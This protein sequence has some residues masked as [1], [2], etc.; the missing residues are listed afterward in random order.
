MPALRGV[1]AGPGTAVPDS[2]ATP[3]RGPSVLL[4]LPDVPFPLRRN[5]I[6]MRYA[7]IIE[8]LGR[9][10]RLHLMLIL[11]EALTDAD[12]ALI[13]PHVEQLSVHVR[14][15]R[16]W[17]LSQRVATRLRNLLPGARPLWSIAHDE[18][19]IRRFVAASTASARYDVA[20]VV[21]PRHVD[22]VRAEAPCER[23]V[24]DAIDSMTVLLERSR[25]TGFFDRLE[26]RRTRRWERSRAAHADFW[27]YVSAYDAA[28]V[29]GEHRDPTRIGVVPNGY[30]RDDHTVERVALPG[31]AIGFLG[32]M[33]YPPNIRAVQRLVPIFRAV[34]RRVPDAVLLIIGRTPAPE[35]TALGAEPGVIVTGTLESIWPHVNATSAFAFPME[36]GAG[37]QNKLLDAM[38]AGVPVVTTPV[39]NSG[40]GAVDG[41]S[42]LIREDDAAFVEVLTALLTDRAMRERIGRQGQAFC[43]ATFD[44]GATLAGIERHYLGMS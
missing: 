40:V 44:W 39:G 30:S 15:H 17:P 34:R 18:A 38:A 37:Q 20:W 19:E 7:P 43:E 27:G 1:D 24:V 25:T 9:R 29:F 6:S 14:Q 10:C 33:G 23:F 13:L 2:G 4:S 3:A 35:V 41:E 28:A 36:L 8:H 42:I 22:A 31:P 12:R 32:N 21:S 16:G 26:C 5:G 11:D